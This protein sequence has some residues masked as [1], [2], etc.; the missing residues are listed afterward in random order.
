[1]SYLKGMYVTDIFGRWQSHHDNLV[2]GKLDGFIRST[3]C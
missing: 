3:I 2:F 1:M